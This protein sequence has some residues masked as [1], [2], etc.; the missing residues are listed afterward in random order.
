ML[1]S[2]WNTELMESVGVAIG[3]EAKEYGVD[4]HLAPAL[5]I[6][7]NPLCGRNFEYYSEDPSLTGKMAAAYTRGVQKNGVTACLKHFAA[8]NSETNRD[9]VDAHLSQRALREIYLRGFEIAVKEGNAGSI[10]T[11]YNK[12]NGVYTSADYDLLT[13]IVRDEWGFKGTVM[14]DWFGGISKTSYT[15]GTMSNTSMQIKAGND[16]LM[17]GTKQQREELLSDVTTGKLQ[18]E[19][20]Y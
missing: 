16:L 10:M 20:S 9:K 4:V 1:A 3:M 17:P 8:N 12:I 2:T 19:L 13:T 15:D 7:R 14:T 11:S 6:M 5:N 18:R